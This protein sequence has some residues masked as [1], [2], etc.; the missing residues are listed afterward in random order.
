MG[1]HKNLELLF[2]HLESTLEELNL[3]L[4]ND[5]DSGVDLLARKLL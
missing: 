2:L 5:A 4:V 3:L 1:L